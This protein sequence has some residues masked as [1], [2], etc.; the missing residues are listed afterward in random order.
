MDIK[1][2]FEKGL[3][4]SEIARR[5]GH[6]RKTIRKMVQ[7]DHVPKPAKRERESIL[8]PFKDYLIGRMAEGVLNAE[9]LYSEIKEKG[10][11]GTSRHLRN[12]IAPFRPVIEAQVT[13][14]FETEPGHQAQVDWGH[15]GYIVED[16]I[17][18]PLYGFVMILS[19]SRM[20]YLEFTTRQDLA[21]LLKCHINAF[22][23]FGGIP[24]EILYDN[25]KT[26][27]TGRDDR[28]YPLFQPGFLDFANYYGFIPKVCRPYRPRTKGKVERA[29]RY[30]KENFYAGIG[31]S[32]LEDLNV[33]AGAWRDHTANVREHGTTH[34]RPVDMMEEEN[35]LSFRERNDYDIARF[36]QRRVSKDCFICLYQNRYSVPWQ[37]AGRDVII[38]ENL[39]GS[40]EII[41]QGKSIATHRLLRGKLQV[42]TQ[43]EHF[44]GID[45]GQRPKK[46]VIIHFVKEQVQVRSL[47]EYEAYA[48]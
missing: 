11:T 37:Y 25:M 12:F 5:T 24:K 27:T 39:D 45:K 3:S 41:F 43:K 7:M 38:K 48:G 19:Y 20:I 47:S 30:V 14:R 2:I 21:A 18:K 23:F 26:V 1:E 40:L 42:A 28:G 17:R 10:Y 9:K 8:D 13:V 34:R 44:L 36:H 46:E 29:I 4:I 15:F 6:D 31:F 22:H 32:S 35:L 33:K 16:G